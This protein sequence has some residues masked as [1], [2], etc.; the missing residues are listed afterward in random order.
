LSEPACR[1]PACAGFQRFRRSVCDALPGKGWAGLLSLLP[2]DEAL[3]AALEPL[4]AWSGGDGVARPPAEWARTLAGLVAGIAPPSPETEPSARGAAVKA[5]LRAAESAARLLPAEAIHL[6]DFWEQMQPA[7]AAASVRGPGRRRDAVHLLDV[8][9]ARQ[10]E[11]PVVFVCGLKEGEFPRRPSSDP[12]LSGSLRLRLRQQGFPLALTST[13]EAEERFVFEIAQTRATHRAFYCWPQF[14]EAGE[15]SLRSFAL[16]LVAADEAPARRVRM[17]PVVDVPLLPPASLDDHRVRDGLAS[18]FA[19]HRTTSLESFL[20]CPFQFYARFTAEL[21]GEPERP[22]GRL[23]PLF[24][25]IVLHDVLKD[26]HQGGGAIERIFDSVWTRAL[27]RKRIPPGYAVEFARSVL[28]RSLVG[29]A[30]EMPPEPG[31]RTFVESPFEL[32]LTGCRV[33][34]RIDRYDIDED[35][36]ARVFDF[37]FSSGASL[38]L[39]KRKQEEGLSLQGGLYLLAL[40]RQGLVPLEFHYVGVKNELT[41][42][43]WNEPEEVAALI[44]DARLL[45]EDAAFQILQGRIEVNPRDPGACAWCDYRDACRIQSVRGAPLAETA[46]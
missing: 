20:Q 23:N 17:K 46:G 9:E 8:Y 42:S 16:D 31:W 11:L 35:R 1:A 14:N 4:A 3:R 34:G 41:I 2:E 39:R 44:E 33:K 28:R 12:V 6:S 22:A 32:E 15:P 24:T 27:A 7:L 38:K 21:Q 5:F 36:Q 13:L 30:L 40:Q 26:W 10:W 37:K 25:G 18:K 43:G 19:V 29:F 45:A